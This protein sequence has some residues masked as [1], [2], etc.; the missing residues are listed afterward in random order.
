MNKY[1]SKQGKQMASKKISKITL[2]LDERTL[3]LINRTMLVNMIST[4]SSAVRYIVN[5]AY[6]SEEKILNLINKRFD[7]LEAITEEK[8]QNDFRNI[9]KKI[10]EK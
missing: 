9:L 1:K 3:Q 5:T 2:S 4:R 10:E 8:I 6:L 7:R